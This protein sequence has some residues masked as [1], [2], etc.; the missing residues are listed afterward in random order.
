MKLTRRLLKCPNTF[1]LNMVNNYYNKCHPIFRN[2]LFNL[3]LYSS[4]KKDY[5]FNHV[6]DSSID[7]VYQVRDIINYTNQKRN[8]IFEQFT[9]CKFIS[10]EIMWN[11][12]TK[13]TTIE[14][15]TSSFNSNTV[16]MRLYK[17]SRIREC[18][19][20]RIEI[21]NKMTKIFTMLELLGVK[22]ETINIYYAPVDIPKTLPSDNHFGIDTI[23]SGG[24]IHDNL[25]SYIVLFRKEESDKVLIHE[26]VHYLRLDFS[27]SEIYWDNKF[28]ISKSVID[29]FNVNHDYSKI[30]LF[31]ALTDCIGIIFNGIFNCIISKSNINDYI[32]TEYAYCLSTAH[33]IIRHSGFKNI[34]EFMNKNNKSVL[35]QSTSVLS[36]YI[37]KCSLMNNTNIVFD[38]YFP[39]FSDDWT[40]R[41]IDNFYGLAKKDLILIKKII[42]N[43]NI[44]NS[45]RMTYIDLKY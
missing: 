35:I 36:Y 44:N 24:T 20:Q 7:K 32:Y 15:I 23:N 26:L 13:H 19:N 17:D 37:L 38:K 10:N 42:S 21:A 39:K 18:F 16:N 3:N 28:M 33:R 4:G 25:K 40:L 31:E 22:N 45:L 11:I 5:D 29:E 12:L 43:S 1:N 30:N 9:T 8:M 14:D 34:H 41:D 6:T 2:I 27:M